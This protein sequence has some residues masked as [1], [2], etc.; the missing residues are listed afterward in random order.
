MDTLV[1]YTCKSLIKL[2][3]ELQTQSVPKSVA[4][5]VSQLLAVSQ[6]LGKFS[7]M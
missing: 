6:S 3:P 5:S 2:T 4:Q 7:Y 1:N